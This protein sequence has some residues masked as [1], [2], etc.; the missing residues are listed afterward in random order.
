MRGDMATVEE[1]TLGMKKFCSVAPLPIR[2]TAP[3]DFLDV[4]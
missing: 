4:L 3:T 2:P 1:G